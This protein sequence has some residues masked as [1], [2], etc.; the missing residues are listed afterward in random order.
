[1]E[2]CQN[3]FQRVESEA[4]RRWSRTKNK[5]GAKEA[6]DDLMK[7]EGLEEIKLYF[8][9]IRESIRFA[10]IQGRK[11]ENEN[12]NVAFEGNPGTGKTSVARLYHALL[13][14]LGIVATDI[15]ETSGVELATDGPSGLR[16][17]VRLI[18][19]DEDVSGTL[20][21]DESYQMLSDH[22]GRQVLDI[23][24][25]S[26]SDKIGKLV[27]IFA[28][29]KKQMEPFFE[30]NQGLTS[31]I[32]RRF[33][34]PNFP[35]AGLWEIFVKH[36]QEDYTKMRFEGG[37]DGIYVQIA[38]QRLERGSHNASFG[39]ARAVQACVSQMV[40]RQLSRLSKQELAMSEDEARQSDTKQGKSHQ[41]LAR[42]I[43]GI[44]E[45]LKRRGRYGSIE[46]TTVLV[47]EDVSMNL[48]SSSS[49]D[50]CPDDDRLLDEGSDLKER[51]C[52]LTRDDI[53]GPPPGQV[54]ESQAWRQLQNLVGLDE[55]K[56]SVRTLI[57][58]LDLN[59][60][61]ECEGDSVIQL[62]L[63]RVFVGQPGTGKTTVAK[64][65]GQILADIGLLSRG[66]VVIKTPADFIAA[67]VGGSEEKTSKILEA[68]LGSVLI[69]DEA[70]MF[71]AGDDGSTTSNYKASVLD[72]IVANVQGD[73]NEDRCILLLG[74]EDRLKNMFKNMNPGLSR[75]FQASHPWRFADYGPSDMKEILTRS[76]KQEQ[77][78]YTQ[79]A[80]KTA[81]EILQ[82]ASIRPDFAN[83]A[84]VGHCLAVAKANYIQ[85]IS[86]LPH[87]EKSGQD[88]FLPEDFD[89]D[90]KSK[91]ESLADE[92]LENLGTDVAN[93]LIS[94]EQTGRRAIESRLPNPHLVLSNL[95]AF[96]GSPG[97]GKRTAARFLARIYYNLGCLSSPEVVS[98]TGPDFIGR[99]VGQTAPKTRDLLQKA[100][101]KV[102]LIDDVLGLNHEPYGAEA[103]GEMVQFISGLS[104]PKTM[105]IILTDS[106][107]NVNIL[108]KSRPSLKAHFR[109]E[110][111][112]EDLLPDD[113]I[114]LLTRE[115]E[116]QSVL[117]PKLQKPDHMHPTMS[118]LRHA[119]HKLQQVPGFQ[120]AGDMIQIARRVLVKILEPGMPLINNPDGKGFT[121]EVAFLRSC[122]HEMAQQRQRQYVV[123]LQ[124]Q[125]PHNTSRKRTMRSD[126]HGP[127]KAPRTETATKTE[128]SPA[129]AVSKEVEVTKKTQEKEQP[130]V[131]EANTAQEPGQSHVEREKGVSD[132]VWAQ[133]QVYKKEALTRNAT[134]E[135]KKKQ[136]Q[137]QQKLRNSG[138]CEFGYEW[139]EEHGGYRCAGGMHF[140]NH[141]DIRDLQ[142]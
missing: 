141:S 101:G 140:M 13:E 14:S 75:R 48:G 61:R 55:V 74:Y 26:M 111:M 96:K 9:N 34:F 109:D 108:L 3:P 125:A 25:K 102:L 113:C 137:I 97:T 21:I 31:R 126:D 133:L 87:N 135:Q 95:L 81:L 60:K 67:H 53:I 51:Y 86:K 79:E 127:R 118:S 6:I 91:H 5:G 80:F 69:I 56:S 58:S 76:M 12:Y 100:L 19:K 112:F 50:E 28:G 45:D 123:M 129:K 124:T 29:Y 71:D 4:A 23:V 54:F 115:L 72:T 37:V 47:S 99:Y 62:P 83:A 77:L 107:Q 8:L 130:K 18:L 1:M 70:Y 105:V 10:R 88:H 33:H 32:G 82:R 30:Y 121:V 110:I 24:L 93:R 106:V 65:Y 46:S 139:I 103:L 17:D 20:F 57:E 92:M 36:V 27:V 42:G 7:Y 120:N 39:N 44:S 134:A 131:K 90:L 38:I 68:T 89:P 132:E 114:S 59:Y 15:V 78:K 49:S 98:H 119:I 117:L 122:V 52:L 43:Q 73:C 40:Q 22:Q 2:P 94:Y 64:L 85:R 63:N 35:K 136:E 138:V 66:D 11:P 16:R 116:A 84:E 41:D 142:D 128:A 104:Y